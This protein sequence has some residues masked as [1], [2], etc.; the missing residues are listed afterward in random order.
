MNIFKRYFADL[1][2]LIPNPEASSTAKQMTRFNELMMIAYREFQVVTHE[3]VLEMRKS[4]QLKVILGLDTYAKRSI[5]RNMTIRTTLSK[6][7]NQFQ[8]L[9]TYEKDSMFFLCDQFFTVL[10]YYGNLGDANSLTSSSTS[11]GNSMKRLS[12]GSSSLSQSRSKSKNDKLDFAQFNM[13]VDRITTWGA[14][15]K[16][17]H[18]YRDIQHFSIVEVD[19]KPIVGIRFI[20]MLFDYI[21]KAGYEYV[22]FERCVESIDRL[23]SCSLEERIDAIF[24]MHDSDR[25]GSLDRESVIQLS[26]TLL[27]LLR[28]HPLTEE[29]DTG[30]GY[31]ASVSALLSRCLLSDDNLDCDS[32]GWKISKDLFRR[33]VVSDPFFHEWFTSGLP[34][35]FLLASTSAEVETKGKKNLRLHYP[36]LG[37]GVSTMG[38]E[39]VDVL[40]TGGLRLAGFSTI[41]KAPSQSSA[42]PHS[43]A[44]GQKEDLEI[45]AMPGQGAEAEDNEDDDDAEDLMAE[46][47]Q[48]LQ[49]SEI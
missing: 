12:S 28:N 45:I 10:Y 35:T 48:M 36:G 32:E 34:A 44:P 4:H 3:I 20:R 2:S 6:V 37:L 1:G 16:D 19:G 27:F 23:V 42:S 13:Y 24:E 11:S 49:N 18:E 25:N 15:A 22:T 7:F 30:D 46:V 26:E 38:K 5:V 41:K 17:R 31:L 39:V 8:P 29:S 21:A 43:G 47:E 9:I 33:L 40:W 14:P